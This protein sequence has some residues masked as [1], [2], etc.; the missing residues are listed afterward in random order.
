MRRSASS[1]V[2]STT[3]RLWS[4]RRGI[5]RFSRGSAADAQIAR[6]HG[7][8]ATERLDA[9]QDASAESSM[10]KLSIALLLQ[11]LADAAVEVLGPRA[12]IESG[13]GAVLDGKLA[14][15]SR[16][17]AATTIAGG[18]S[19]IQRKNISRRRVGAAS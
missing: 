5:A 15:L 13:P 10:A 4:H 14:A 12:L 16:A 6:L 17:A 2:F 18:V 9:R 11:E 7:R 1:C 3:W 8:R 19:D